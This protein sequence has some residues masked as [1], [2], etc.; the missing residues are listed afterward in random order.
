[1]ITLDTSAI[2][3]LLDRREPHHGPAVA[4]LKADAG[5]YLVP[6]GIFAEVGFMIERRLGPAVLDLFLGDLE[7]GAFVLDC[8]EGDLRRIRELVRRCADL[9]LGTADASVVACAERSG[10]RVLTFDV[11]DF[12]AV[13]REASIALVP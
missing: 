1:M 7:A 2:L 4:A 11:R 10:G 13:A 12:G 3:A 8:G 6:A 9:P 5:P